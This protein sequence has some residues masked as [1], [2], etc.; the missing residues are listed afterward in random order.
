[1]RM[2]YALMNCMWRELW[3]LIK[4]K[5]R[6]KVMYF[7]SVF[8]EGL[9][10]FL[11]YQIY[12]FQVKFTFSQNLLLQNVIVGVCWSDRRN[13]DFVI[14]FGAVWDQQ[15]KI[16]ELCN[17]VEGYTCKINIF[18]GRVGGGVGAIENISNTL[19]LFVPLVCLITTYISFILS[20]TLFI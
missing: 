10:F 11:L 7:L 13:F 12:E 8:Q 18:I 9:F 3:T 16:E 4:T 1:M 20:K 17:T 5:G 14:I 2:F 6:T 15:Q 19:P